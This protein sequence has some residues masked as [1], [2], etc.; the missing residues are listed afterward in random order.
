MAQTVSDGVRTRLQHVLGVAVQFRRVP[1]SEE[2]NHPLFGQRAAQLIVCQE[3]WMEVSKRGVMRHRRSSECVDG[4]NGSIGVVCALDGAHVGG[5]D[6]APTM[7][8]VDGVAKA[9][10]VD[11]VLLYT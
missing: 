9:P 11:S 4:R 6:V 2:V 5:H 3:G 8:H 7:R 1:Q 10:R